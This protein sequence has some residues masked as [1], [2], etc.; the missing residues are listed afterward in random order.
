MVLMG[1]L[2]WF[3]LRTPKL[4]EGAISEG[5][6]RDT[7]DYLIK[8]TDPR[9]ALIGGYRNRM[10]D[11]VIKTLHFIGEVRDLMLPPREVSTSAWALDPCVKALFVHPDELVEVFSRSQELKAFV[12]NSGPSDPVYAVLGA[13]VEERRRF[14][15][16]VQGGVMVHDVAQVTLNFTNH[17]LRIF[18]HSEDDLWQ[19]IARRV[20]DELAVAALARMEA[21]QRTRK[22]LENSRNLL[23]A[24]LAVFGRRGTGVDSFLG[25][26]GGDVAHEESRALL[27]ELEQNETLLAGLGSAEDWLERQFAYLEEVLVDPAGQLSVSR[28]EVRLDAMNVV[29]P[30]SLAGADGGSG[31]AVA[32]NVVCVARQPER[33]HAMIPVLVDRKVIRE[34]PPMSLDEAERWI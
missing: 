24:R 3:R 25:E 22:E 1:L 2:D 23:N 8:M 10:E 29:Q 33:T 31:E 21:E 14:G 32:F 13:E 17:Q 7:A 19:S 4:S 28:R 6:V 26:A 27:H 12:D 11:A 15:I 5:L 34:L 20:L 30:E 9:L 18:G 16:V